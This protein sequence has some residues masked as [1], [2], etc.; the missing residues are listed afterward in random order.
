M[1]RLDPLRR[2]IVFTRRRP[3]GTWDAQRFPLVTG[4][5][6]PDCGFVVRASW[7]GDGSTDVHRFEDPPA[8]RPDGSRYAT[9]FCGGIESLVLG[10]RVRAARRAGSG[11]PWCCRYFAYTKP[12]LRACLAELLSEELGG[13]VRAWSITPGRVGDMPG[14]RLVPDVMGVAEPVVLFDPVEFT[15]AGPAARSRL[16]TAC[17]YIGS[18]TTTTDEEETP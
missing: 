18:F 10:A 17:G 13:T 3:D 15:C 12:T 11:P 1:I 8:A 7:E 16:A 5:A 6:C 9:A 4:H 14:L 2:D